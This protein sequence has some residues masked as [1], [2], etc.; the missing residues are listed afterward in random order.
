MAR[1]SSAIHNALELV[2]SYL[3]DPQYFWTLATLAVI[4]DGVLTGFIIKFIP[5]TEIDWE[6]YMVQTELY[7]KGQYNY[8]LIT[9]PT[10]PLVYPAGHVRIHEFLY[11]FTD[12]GRNVRRVQHIYGILYILILIITCAVYRKAGNVPNWIVMLL[13]LSKRLHSIFV[14][15]LFNDC[16]AVFLMTLAVLAL[17]HGLD[18][19]A[20]LFYSAAL[21]VK[22]SI[23]LHLPGIL[24]VTF[25]RGGLASTLRYLFTIVAVQALLASPF[26][27]EDSWSYL[28]GAF[29]LG[30]VFLY[31]WTVNWRFVD[32]ATF[33]SPT[34]ALSLLVGHLSVL[35]AFG[36]FRWCKPDGNVWKILSRGLRRP[37]Q[38]AGLTPTTPDYIVTVLFTSNLI[39]II[40]ARSLHYQFYSWYAMQ[41]PFLA[42]R[43]R[44]PFPIKLTLLMAIEYA[45]NIYP[46]TNL[47]SGVL[48]AGNSLLLVGVWFGFPNGKHTQTLSTERS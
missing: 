45:W 29:D 24:V 38:P 32:E 26:L 6:T 13:P 7:I 17:E 36:L 23:L 16:W 10:G 9:G 39:G 41:V 28:K 48:L 3:F 18:D 46:S 42:W 5:Y 37:L 44:Y 22:M 12:A 47:S 27:S 35:L 11:N 43:T 2:K 19:T 30:R 8:T 14:L 20:I 15:R 34:F 40:F 4:V 21:S 31:K 1:N 25:R 33:L